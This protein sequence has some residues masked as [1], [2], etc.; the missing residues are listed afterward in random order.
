MYVTNTCDVCKFRKLIKILSFLEPTVFS[1]T[2]PRTILK[3][4]WYPEPIQIIPDPNPSHWD[5]INKASSKTS[6]NDSTNSVTSEPRATTENLF[7]LEP[8]STT[9]KTIIVKVPKV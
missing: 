3:N 1:T 8:E 5:E 9:K 6:R 4:I 2:T 7:P